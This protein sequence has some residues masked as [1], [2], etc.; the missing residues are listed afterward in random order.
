MIRTSLTAQCIKW[1]EHTYAMGSSE[2]LVSPLTLGES[3]TTIPLI[4]TPLKKGKSNSWQSCGTTHL[5]REG[6]W[7]CLHA[8]RPW[9]LVP[10]PLPACHTITLQY[11]TQ[12]YTRSFALPEPDKKSARRRRD[13]SRVVTGTPRCLES[14]F[15]PP[16]CRGGRSVPGHHRQRALGVQGCFSGMPGVM[17]A[18]GH[19]CPISLPQAALPR[20]PCSSRPGLFTPSCCLDST[21]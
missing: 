18:L 12:D 8:F 10:A 5:K 20:A 16:L 2:V 1:P 9:P 4:T 14:K 17:A 3:T 15:S 7:S 6:L 11:E 21:V 19:E 13:T